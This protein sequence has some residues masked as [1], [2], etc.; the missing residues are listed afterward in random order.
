[1]LCD[2]RDPV[3]QPAWPH[4]DREWP[5]A[6]IAAGGWRLA[7]IDT[8]PP[9]LPDAGRAPDWLAMTAGPTAD[10]VVPLLCAPS[11]ATG[12]AQA[13]TV[14]TL[15]EA[16]GLAP[17]SWVLALVDI[18]TGPLPRPVRAALT[19]LEHRV[20]A[21]VSIPYDGRIRA[22]GLT[23]PERLAA[24]SRR[25]GTRLAA[26]VLAARHRPAPLADHGGAAPAARPAEGRPDDRVPGRQPAAAR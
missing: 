15:A 4:R 5:S 22:A 7:V 18:A 13:I 20:H 25:A 6:L 9:L 16:A 3:D 23:D 10:E 1:M 11:S 24:S 21:I 12:V 2:V 19:L 8:G 17:R 14:A 26:A